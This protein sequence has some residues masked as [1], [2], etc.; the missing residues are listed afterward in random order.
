MDFIKIKNFHASKGTVK[1]V[2]R[3]T[4]IEKKIANHVL[5]KGLVIR[6]Y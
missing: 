3:Q 2:R 5:S 4:R 6:V 1:K